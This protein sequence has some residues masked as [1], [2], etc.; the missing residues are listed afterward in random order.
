MANAAFE[1]H[2]RLYSDGTESGSVALLAEDDVA[3]TFTSA[4]LDTTY[5]YR[6]QIKYDHCSGSQV[7]GQN[8]TLNA[9]L[10][11]RR[12][13][14]AWTQV[15]TT[16]NYVRITATSNI[17]DGANTTRRLTAFSGGIAGET[18]SGT[19]QF[20]EASGECAGITIRRGDAGL[21]GGDPYIYTECLFSI[22]F[23]S[24]DLADADTIELR[25]T[26]AG[27]A[28]TCGTSY[29]VTPTY[30]FSLASRRMFLVT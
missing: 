4:N 8:F 26:D 30:T 21:E 24:A 17:A 23:R 5:L 27:T 10:E 9:R 22:Q 14:G 11:Y 29:P 25:I 16:S 7:S 1:T 15:T 2:Q 12:N 6:T 20:D 18:F 3:E 19:A 13:G 28:F